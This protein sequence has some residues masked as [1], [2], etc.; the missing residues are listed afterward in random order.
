MLLSMFIGGFC[1]GNSQVETSEGQ[2]APF[3]KNIEVW[4]QLWRVIE[5]SDVVVQ[6]VDARNPLLFRYIF[7]FLIENV[8]ILIWRNTPTKLIL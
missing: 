4:R 2:V 5:M 1:N 3:E 6:I 8:V 7:A